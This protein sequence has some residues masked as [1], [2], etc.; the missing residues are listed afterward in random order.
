ME[1]SQSWAASEVSLADSAGQAM[2][3]KFDTFYHT[4]TTTQHMTFFAS[5]GDNGATDC[6]TLNPSPPCN[7]SP[8]ATTAFP[9]SDPWVTSV[10]GTT[11]Q[12][13]GTQLSEIGWDGSGGGFS[14]FYATPNYQQGL[15]ASVQQQLNHRRG[16][17]DVAASADPSIGL[18]CFI[19][20]L[21]GPFVGNGTSAGSPLWAGLA[22]I[23]NQMAGRPLGYLNPALYTIAQGANYSRDFHDITVGNNSSTDNSVNVPGYDAVPGWDPMTGLGTPNAQYLLP[24]LIAAV[25]AGG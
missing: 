9:T 22:A 25:G 2:I 5:S 3:A 8:V 14:S 23:A 11:I 7:L 1:F 19:S 4:A 6:V 10:G 20:Q 16:V 24:D 13:S 15:S 12:E 21:P 17:P 18:G